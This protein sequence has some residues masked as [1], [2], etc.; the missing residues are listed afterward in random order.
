MYMRSAH[1]L[2]QS[3]G[4]EELDAT[5]LGSAHQGAFQLKARRRPCRLCRKYLAK[6]GS[7]HCSTQC[8][9]ARWVQRALIRGN[10]EQ[11]LTPDQADAFMKMVTDLSSLPSNAHI[12]PFSSRIK[13]Y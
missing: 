9:R 13:L 12:V 10:E 3:Q 1:R 6:L 7:L 4:A 5:R 8:W 2:S 11:H